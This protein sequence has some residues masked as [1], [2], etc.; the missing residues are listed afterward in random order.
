MTIDTY[1]PS[2]P[3]FGVSFDG[4]FVFNTQTVLEN[5]KHRPTLKK[6]N[7]KV[8][9]TL[10]RKTNRGTI[11]DTPI[12]EN[13]DP[14]FIQMDNNDIV[15]VMTSDI[16][17][18]DPNAS[19][20]DIP[21]Q[22]TNPPHLSWIKTGAKVTMVPPGSQTPKQGYLKHLETIPGKWEFI[23]GCKKSNPS[24]PLPDFEVNI[25]S[26]LDNK[27]LFKG[28]LAIS[29]TYYQHIS[30]KDL[31][32]LKAPSL[33]KH[34]SLPEPDR[35]LWNDLCAGENRSLQKLEMWREVTDKE[36]DSLKPVI[37]AKF[38]PTMAISTIE[39]GRNGNS[40]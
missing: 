24:V 22:Q 35:S 12:N 23:I 33:S 25:H 11:I 37:K 32:I 19:P 1:L 38:H 31:T 4:N 28:C 34:N 8:Y 39:Y 29:N 16:S 6:N 36:Y 21:I 26:H 15:E 40:K 13:T 14:Y 17:E 10:D 5:S 30:A 9:V 3:E 27:K 7:T 18:T 20:S 2:G